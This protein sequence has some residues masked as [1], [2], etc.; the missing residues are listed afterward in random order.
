MHWVIWFFRAFYRQLF[1]DI[2]S[3]S[4]K[5]LSNKPKALAFRSFRNFAGLALS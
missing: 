4:Q 1:F 2:F 3:D 5:Y